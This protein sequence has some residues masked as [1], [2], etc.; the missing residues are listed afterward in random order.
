MLASKRLTIVGL[1]AALLTL[2]VTCSC[3][4]PESSQTKQERVDRGWPKANAASEP[5]T[6]L[7]LRVPLPSIAGAKYVQNDALCKVCHADYVEAF[8][9]NVHRQ[10]NC[11]ACHGPASRH[12]ESRGK[13]PDS[14]LSFKKLKKA[15]R[16]EICAQCHERDAC[17]PGSEWRTSE[18]AHRGVACTD[19]HL[20]NHYNVPE[21]TPAATPDLALLEEVKDWVHYV[22]QRSSNANSNDQDAEREARQAQPSL[23]GTSNN[24]GAVAPYVCYTCHNEKY[25]LERIGHSHQVNGPHAIN[26][27]T[28]HDPHGNVLQYAKKQLCVECHS[29]TETA[30][31]HSSLHDHAGVNC[32]DC[33]NP[34]PDSKLPT[35]GNV[36]HTSIQRT[37]R[38]PM[39]VNDPVVCYKCHQEMYGMLQLPSHHPVAEGKMKCGDCHDAHGQAEGNL[40]AETVNL[41]CYKCHAEKQG[42]FVHQHAPVEENCSICHNPHGT[43]TNNLLHQPTTFLC[44]R[45]H[46]GHRAPPSSHFGMGTSDIDN[47]DWVRPVLYTDCTQ[48]HQQVH[49]SDLPS[50]Q[51]TDALM[52]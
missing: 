47:L 51:Q 46:T 2:A 52:R 15:E 12:V 28:C 19:C 50:Q 6:H 25:D 27:Q 26:C 30:A 29:A 49:G 48:C 13:D 5:K 32:T 16:S 1:T 14:I 7:P 39:S 9:H 21:G 40:I 43:V 11:E 31:F 22:S 35:F 24:L 3:R 34:H 42:P 36:D 10:N 41:T 8:A 44:L 17:A 37:P 45:C 4:W 33:H 20:R 38:L 18:H 23:R